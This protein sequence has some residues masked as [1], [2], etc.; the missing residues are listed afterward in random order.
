MDQLTAHLDRGWDLVSRGDL[1]GA[2]VSAQK[3]LEVDGASPEVHNLLGYV[4]SAEGH[5]DEALEHYRQAIELDETFVEAMLNAAE[6][7][8]GPSGDHGQALTLIEDALDLM[9]ED[10]ERADALLLKVD[11]LLAMGDT[12]GASRVVRA[13]PEGPFDNPS[14]ALL[15]GRAKLETGD[16][17]GAE[18]HL[19]DAVERDSDNPEAHYFLGL[20]LEA[21]ED[22]HGAML[23]FLRCR[24]L[25]L[26]IGDPPWALAPKQFEREVELA[27]PRLPTAM[28]E[29]LDGA[30]VVVVEAPGAEVVA[31]GV[32]P[33]IEVL[34]DHVSAPDEA[35]RVGR[36]FVYQRNVERIAQGALEVQDGIV[37][38]LAN[39]LVL[40]FPPLAVS[41]A[42]TDDELGA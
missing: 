16:I 30:L 26:S 14:I 19:R 20:L 7:L 11:A 21:R 12:E 36:V 25:D 29:A 40:A 42:K 37:R 24:E 6:V 10:E 35:P 4:L 13:L 32:D 15:V 39:E 31:D 41:L 9:D 23:A 18:P 27:L 38:A 3:A 1:A 5:A 34:L 22:L 2:F 17:D 8:L 28:R 33:R